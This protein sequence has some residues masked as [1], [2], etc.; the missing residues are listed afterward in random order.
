MSEEIIVHLNASKT[1][2]LVNQLKADGLIMHQD[3]EWEYIPGTYDYHT[4]ET[5]KPHAVFTFTEPKHAVLY[6]MKWL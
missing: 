2:D 1:V 4:M 3:F 6:A 5:G